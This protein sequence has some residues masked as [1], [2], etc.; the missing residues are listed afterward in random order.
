MPAVAPRD[1][2]LCANGIRRQSSR[3]ASG[4]WAPSKPARAA[5]TSLRIPRVLGIGESG[6]TQ[7]PSYRP[8]PRFSANWPKRLRSIFAP[9]LDASM[10]KCTVSAAVS[11]HGRN[12]QQKRQAKGEPNH[13]RLHEDSDQ[14]RRIP[15]EPL[16]AIPRD[17]GTHP[18]KTFSRNRTIQNCLGRAQIK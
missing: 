17:Q 18:E 8:C 13:A 3:L 2:Y 6:P 5:T 12:Q 11:W 1:R 10:D 16:T 15:P 7:M 4:H 9:A 14:L